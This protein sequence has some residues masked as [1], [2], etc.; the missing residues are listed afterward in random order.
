MQVSSGLHH[1]LKAGFVVCYVFFV[2]SIS[3]AENIKTSID[4]N[5]PVE[6]LRRLIDEKYSYRDLRGID[7]DKAFSTFGPLMERAQTPEHFAELA[8]KLLRQA[9]DPHIWVKIGD[10]Q[11]EGFKRNTVRNYNIAALRRIVPGFTERNKRIST[12]RFENGIGYI[13]I[14]N[15]SKREGDGL[16]PAF[17]ALK[18]LA[19][20]PGIIIDVRPNNGGS[21]P[22]AEEF[23]GCFVDE[24]VVYS[25]HQYRKPDEPNGFGR[26]QERILK[27]NQNK[28]HYKGKVAVLMGQVNMSSCESFL[29][30]MK[31][32]PNCKLIGQ[33]SY[34]SSG[35]PKPYELGNGVTV[36]LPSWQ[37]LLPDGTCLEGRGVFPDI[38]V[39]TTER[40]LKN[41]DPVIDAAI[42]YLLKQ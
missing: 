27:P 24:P 25:K 37:A 7:W 29:L 1:Y 34:G 26:P 8:A 35:N 21:E 11:F 5:L 16:E 2:S 41:R 4:N 31:Q 28:F 32:S 38:V 15:W 13:M 3:T 9:R 36:L 19:D 12:G 33:K 40:Q 14:A 18:E 39:S 42:K 17:A 22:L 23:A 6:K 10:K 20:S 30:M